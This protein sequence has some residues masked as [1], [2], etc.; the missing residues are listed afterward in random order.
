MAITSNIELCNMALSLLGNYGTIENINT[1]VK[2]KEK[3]FAQWYTT[4]VEY[5]LKLAMPNFALARRVV[6]QVATNPAPFGYTYAYEKPADCLKVL[7]FGD[8]DEKDLSF[9]VEGDYIY[10]DENYTSG[11]ELRFVR[12]ITDETRF[13]PE[14]VLF[15]AEVLAAFTCVAVTQ[16]AARAQALKD[17]LPLRAVELS[18]LNAQENPPIRKSTSKF[19]Q[20]RYGYV[21]RNNEKR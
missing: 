3:I 12:N 9:T 5:A 1:P 15:A 6:S 8:V 11:L 2:A 14:F 7:G 4:A 20:A 17:R 10:T 16:D 21:T 18:G 19:K 13:T